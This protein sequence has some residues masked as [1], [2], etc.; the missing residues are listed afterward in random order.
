MMC[1]KTQVGLLGIVLS[2]GT[3]GFSGGSDDEDSGAEAVGMAARGV[4]S[5]GA[6]AAAAISRAS[7]A[8]VPDVPE[9][10]IPLLDG[11]YADDIAEAINHET[12]RMRE[13]PRTFGETFPLPGTLVA[14]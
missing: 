4:E 7:Q 10:F 1:T 12:Q 2:F 8:I 11:T 9:D 3:P 6:R 13:A 14:P 5:G